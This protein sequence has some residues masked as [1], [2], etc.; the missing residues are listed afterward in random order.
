MLQSNV[1]KGRRFQ[2]VLIKPSHYDD[3]GYVIRWW[4]AMIPSNSLAA[5]YGIAADCAER[6]VLGP[7]VAID[8]EV[9]DETNTRIDI[10]ALHRPLSASRRVRTVSR[11]S[12]CNRISIRARSTSHGRSGQP[13][14]PVAIGGFH[15]SGC[16][17]MLDGHAV[18][19]DAC[20]DLGITIF[21]GEAEGRFESVL[22]R[23]GRGPPRAGIQ[24]HEGSAGH[25]GHAS[26]V[27][28]EAIRRAHA[29][30]SASFD[31]GRGCPYQCSFCTII[32]VQGRKSRYRSADDVEH[33][34]RLNWAQGIRKFFIT[35]DN[36]ARN[37]EWEAIFDRLIELREKRRH[38]A[39]P[40]DPGR[41]AV[42]QDPE[43]HREGEAGRR[44]ARLHR[45]GEHQSG[46]SGGGEEAA[47][48]DHRVSQD[49]A[50]LEGTGHHHARRL[51]PGLSSGH[52]GDRSGAISRSS[53]RNCRS[54][55]WS[56]SA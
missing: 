14:L 27:P 28:A 46:Q 41:Y 45:A 55:F 48:Q 10:P 53:R 52:A 33:L 17:S 11:W 21:A 6:Q 4:R 7:D 51:Y 50:R 49:A 35:D 43:F 2:L 38:P 3:D 13:G 56:F 24:L 40:D 39:R 30:P 16:L 47:E 34:V 22:T 19:L 42:P 26:A 8:I 15:V 36:F 54:T 37:K 31:A 23:R 1:A 5:V 18:D 44:H 20:R 32:N 12:A 29:R 9:I 25:G